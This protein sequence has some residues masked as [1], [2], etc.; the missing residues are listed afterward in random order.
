MIGSLVKTVSK[1]LSWERKSASIAYPDPALF[2]LFGSYQTISGPAVTPQSAMRVPAVKAA[3]ELLS[4]AVSSMPASLFRWQADGAKLPD[5]SHPAAPFIERDANPWTTAIELRR[6]LTCDALLYGGGF[7]AAVRSSDGRVL[8]LQRLNPLGVS[9]Y[10]DLET[11]EPQYRYASPAGGEITYSWRDVVVVRPFV[12]EAPFGVMSPGYSPVVLAKEAIGL[13]LVLEQHAA[14]LFANGGRPAGI[15][16]TDQALTADAAARMRASWQSSQSGRN[17]GGTAIL[18]HNMKYQPM[19][20]SSVD[21]Q[22]AEMRTFQI[23]EIARAFNVPAHMLRD[24]SRATWK[25]NEQANLEFLQ[26]SLQPWLDTWISAYRR[27]LFTDADRENYVIAFNSESLLR[28]DSAMRGEYFNKMRA[29]GVMTA[30]DVRS[31]IN[32]PA[33]PG[34]DKLENPFTTSSSSPAGN[35]ANNPDNNNA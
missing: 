29:A 10:Y 28:S 5:H 19:A 18:E 27:V 4:T 35:T 14:Q 17:A 12:G 2:E 26:F 33:L 13:A 25:N 20:F 16:S 11:T 9:E 30:N 3:V 32:L 34:G 7:A 24:M 31:Q 23:T 15:L 1:A 8:E 21:T 6:Q 22:F